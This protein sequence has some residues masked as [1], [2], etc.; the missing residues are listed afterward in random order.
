MDA[1]PKNNNVVANRILLGAAV[2]FIILPSILFLVE[3]A[4]VGFELFNPKLFIGLAIVSV[5]VADKIYLNISQAR[6]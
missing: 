3:K 1:Q 5:I 6:K 4:G 2:I